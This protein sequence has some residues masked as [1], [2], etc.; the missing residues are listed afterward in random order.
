VAAGALALASVA[1]L[2]PEVQRLTTTTVAR[3]VA[4]DAQN[5]RIG[6]E[7]ARG[8]TD[9]GYRPLY[10]GSLAEPFF[11]GDYGRD[12]VAACVSKW[13]GVDRIHRL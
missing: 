5:A 10:I 3:S 13:Y 11:T 4:W 6:A 12:W 7:A 8:A 1:A 9:V 2:V